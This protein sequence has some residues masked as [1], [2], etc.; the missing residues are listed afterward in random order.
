MTGLQWLRSRDAGLAA[1]RRAGRAAI[2]MP[3]M[4]ALSENVIGNATMATFAA[5]GS[6][7]MLLFVAFG[8]TI[9][10]R[11]QAQIALILTGAVFICLGT[12]A[13]QAVW[14]ATIGMSLAGFAVLFAGV[15]S[16]V[17]AGASTALLL[18]F[19]LQQVAVGQ[20]AEV[21]LVDLAHEPHGLPPRAPG[22]PV[23][24]APDEQ[25]TGQRPG[26][27][28]ISPRLAIS[29]RLNSVIPGGLTCGP[30]GR[31]RGPARPAPS[32]RA[33]RRPSARRPPRLPPHRPPAPPAR[34]PPRRGW[35]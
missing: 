27:A 25:G 4:L 28:A 7:A 9:R 20:R 6:L 22:I 18:G 24:A 35:A 21:L 14:L 30:P 15:V 17:L 31:G 13:G 1:L 3:A 10:E 16:S 12:L 34:G 29:T 11:L 19:I 32:A 2:V 26:G 23:H 33:P 8:G 5:F